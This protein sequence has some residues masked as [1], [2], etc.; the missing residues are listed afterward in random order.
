VIP[1]RNGNSNVEIMIDRFRNIAHSV[2]WLRTPSILI[3]VT[4]LIGFVYIVL[5]STSHEG[6]TL[7]IPSIVGFIWATT[8]AALLST[9][10]NVPPI[11]DPK[12]SFF[13]RVWIR[14]IRGWYWAI[15]LLFIATSFAAL[16]LTYRMISIWVSDY[17][18]S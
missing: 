5:T 9:F 2:S 14:V 17:G 1:H 13:R 4:C 16:I 10:A 8:T 12:Y 7:L 18:N 11:P 15:G 6:D 3:G